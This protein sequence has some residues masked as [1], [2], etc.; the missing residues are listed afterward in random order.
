MHE[1]FFQEHQWVLDGSESF[2]PSI[3]RLHLLG[4]KTKMESLESQC[5]HWH[6]TKIPDAFFFPHIHRVTPCLDRMGCCCLGGSKACLSQTSL[7]EQ[8]EQ[9]TLLLYYQAGLLQSERKEQPLG[10]AILRLPFL[11][12]FIQPFVRASPCHRSHATCQKTIRIIW[13]I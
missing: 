1:G 3:L 6:H 7:K 12:R 4:M 2:V 5:E 8:K 9:H 13:K 11:E 10:E